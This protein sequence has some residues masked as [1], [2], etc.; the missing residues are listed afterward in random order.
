MI[1]AS[2]HTGIA[3][4]DLQRSL[5]FYCDFLGL[6]LWRQNRETGGF[7]SE[8]VGLAEADVEWVKLKTPDGYVIELLQY[9]SH[10][11]EIHESPP[12]ANR[13]GIP[14]I[15]FTVGDLNEV[16]R[17]FQKSEYPCGG[18]PLVNPEG[19]A[20]VLYCRD[21]DGVILEFVEEL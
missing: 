8:L 19:T 10:P 13:V 7:I 21:P 17:C 1:K 20:K 9:H 2:R 11:D 16:W 4:R 15:A 12:L 14:H 3:V 18:A 5:G 6:T